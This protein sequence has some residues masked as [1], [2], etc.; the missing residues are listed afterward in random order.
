MTLK[1]PFNSEPGDIFHF[2]RE[3]GKNHQGVL[4]KEYWGDFVKED[5]SGSRVQNS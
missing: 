4:S 1:V 3:T 2:V 5:S